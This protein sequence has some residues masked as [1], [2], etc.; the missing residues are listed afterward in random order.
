M[1]GY[2]LIFGLVVVDDDGR[3]YNRGSYKVFL[4]GSILMGIGYLQQLLIV[5]YRRSAFGISPCY[6]VID[7]LG[8][9]LMVSAYAIYA[10]GNYI[11][12]CKGFYKSSNIDYCNVTDARL[13][14]YLIPVFGQLFIGIASWRYGRRVPGT[15]PPVH[16]PPVA[17]VPVAAAVVPAVGAAVPPAPP[18]PIVVAIPVTAPPSSAPV[19]DNNNNNDQSAVPYVEAVPMTQLSSPMPDEQSSSSIPQSSLMSSNLSVHH[20]PLQDDK[21]QLAVAT[22]ILPS[23][24]TITNSSIDAIHININ[25]PSSSSSSSTT[26]CVLSNQSNNG[27]TFI[28]TTQPP[29]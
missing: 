1:I 22:S 11:E 24:D 4:T 26:S 5:I 29:L 3:G 23:N 28:D 25:D 8:N 14:F 7:W 2:W 10:R 16:V 9:I 27:S 6:Q 17:A 15:P 12:L 21:V 19:H 18:P 13:A 20:Q